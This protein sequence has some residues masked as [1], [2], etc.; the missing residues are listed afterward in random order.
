MSSEFTMAGVECL[1]KMQQLKYIYI[2]VDEGNGPVGETKLLVHIAGRVPN[3]KKIEF[4]F[5]TIRN[6]KFVELYGDLYPDKNLLVRH[7]K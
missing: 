6:W 7:L 3:L 1:A 2:K 4:E 5:D